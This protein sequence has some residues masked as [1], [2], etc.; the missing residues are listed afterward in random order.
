[1]TL[2][3]RRSHSSGPALVAPVQEVPSRRR[4]RA[5]LALPLSLAFAGIPLWW[6]LGTVQIVFFLMAIP[7]AVYLL[8]RRDV[9]VPR[10][11]G[12]WL[13][14]L[15]WVLGG[16]LVLQVDAPG[17]VPGESMTRYLT[18]VYRFGWYLVGTVALLYVTSTR[19][20]LA[21]HNI[22][23]ALSWMFLALLGGGLLGVTVP[24]LEFPSLLEVILPRNLVGIGFVNDLIHP[25]VAQIHTFLGYAEPRPS[26]PFAYTNDWGLSTALTAPFFIV[27]WWKRGGWHRI[28]VPIS[29]GLSLIPIIS[30][31][32]RGLWLALLVMVAFA[33]FRIG[34]KGHIN[35]LAIMVSGASVVAVVVALS[36]LGT[37]IVDRLNTPHSNQGR[38]NL[39]SLAVGS[40]LEG[41][42]FLGFG[43]TRDVQGNFTSIAGGASDLCPACAPPAM[44]TQGQLWLLIFGTGV[45][46]TLLFVSFFVGQLFRYMRDRSDYSLAAACAVVGCIVTLPVYSAVS[47]A[48]VI[49]LISV[50]VMFRE[51]SRA[52]EHQLSSLLSPVLR[53]WQLV[54]VCG[55]VGAFVGGAIQYSAGA[56]SSVT[57]SVLAP[58]NLVVGPAE[59]RP[60]SMDSEAA[61]A[62][63][64]PVISAIVSAAGT[65]DSESVVSQTLVTADPNSRILNITFTHDDPRLAEAGAK[66]AATAFLAVREEVA[67]DTTLSS[68]VGRESGRVLRHVGPV[69]SNDPWVVK[70]S[71]G[72]MLG[73]LG[74]LLLGRA[75]DGRLDRLR[76]RPERRL[77]VELPTLYRRPEAVV[78]AGARL[79]FHDVSRAL[80]TY[81][82]LCAVLAD[83]TRPSAIKLADSLEAEAIAVGPWSGARVLL[84]ASTRSRSRPVRQLY[85]AC[86]RSGLDPACLVLV[87]EEK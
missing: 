28:M 60:L 33:A 23:N 56:P 38:T 20:S 59:T 71:S 10:G 79:G 70:V 34:L 75:L 50:G 40:M 72:L 82:P 76:R 44:G 9:P 68:I 5:N 51:S 83:Q 37:L 16:V 46:G 42:P 29:I 13:L 8:R 17:A 43:T 80:G 77:G 53:S 61:L 48:I 87:E 41:S 11:A 67:S 6:I 22:T 47:P 7:M 25:Q 15:V 52:S 36:P 65:L 18:F 24:T 21:T 35:A 54:A 69:Q 55:L 2:D 4:T 66:A 58:R 86:L 81:A 19:S 27:T 3:T 62:R 26:A 64:A 39:S 85:R 45:V 84:V 31:V 12:L 49:A 30:S 57:Y 14:F 78:A 63:S 32:N 73:I 74:G 1:M